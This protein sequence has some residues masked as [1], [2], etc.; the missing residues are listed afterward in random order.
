[1]SEQPCK[2]RAAVFGAGI[3][4]IGGVAAA[5]ASAHAESDPRL[6]GAVALVCLAHAPALLALG[7]SGRRDVMFRLAAL[8]LF[9]GAAVFSGRYRPSGVRPRTAFRDGG[10]FRRHCHDG[11]LARRGGRGFHRPRPVAGA[12]TRRRDAVAAAMYFLSACG[13]SC[14]GR[15][16]RQSASAG[17]ARPR[18]ND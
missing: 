10:A 12:L 3:L 7:L 4:G 16:Y 18:G 5:A 8:L 13:E 15:N 2:D 14:N 6:L 11:R 1:M 9:A 17:P